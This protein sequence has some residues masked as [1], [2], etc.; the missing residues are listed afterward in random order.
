VGETASLSTGCPRA[1]SV[2]QAPS[3]A[4]GSAGSAGTKTVSAC[5]MSLSVLDMATPVYAIE[6]LLVM[7]VE[8]LGQA[9]QRYMIFMLTSV[10]MFAAVSARSAAFDR[11][12]YTSRSLNTSSTPSIVSIFC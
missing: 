1:G 11:C 3:T 7:Q 12:R 2:A 5:S 9:S 6:R 4:G 8:D 10:M